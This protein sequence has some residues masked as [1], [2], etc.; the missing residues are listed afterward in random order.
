MPLRKSF[1]N[2]FVV[3]IFERYIFC[4]FNTQRSIRDYK[5][6]EIGASPGVGSCLGK[7]SG[8][9]RL[10]VR[11]NSIHSTDAPACW[12]NPAFEDEYGYPRYFE[13]RTSQL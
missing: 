1:V 11:A 2:R 8:S 13:P 10:R 5:V 6:S 7:I 4:S 12:L 9:G 3:N